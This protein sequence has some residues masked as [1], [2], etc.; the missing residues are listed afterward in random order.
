MCTLL[1]HRNIWTTTFQHKSCIKQTFFKHSQT[2]I[3]CVIYIPLKVDQIS[4]NK[5]ILYFRICLIENTWTTNFF[6]L[7][8]FFINTFMFTWKVELSSD[9]IFYSKMIKTKFQTIRILFKT[10]YLLS[11]RNVYSTGS[12]LNFISKP[13][14][15]HHFNTSTLLKNLPE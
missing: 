11:Y 2:W 1:F 10:L 7:F 4:F 8:H 6:K 12:R 14:V 9:L 5:L 13:F 3:C 15:F